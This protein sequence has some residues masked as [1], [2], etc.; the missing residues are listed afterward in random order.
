MAAVGLATTG[1]SLN[2]ARAGG[3]EPTV[4]TWSGYDEAPFTQSYVDRYGN[5]LEYSFFADEDEAFTK[6]L[7]GF[8]PELMMPG[9]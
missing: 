6:L 9:T 5:K 2:A 3:K 1:F 8:F 7:S 4:F